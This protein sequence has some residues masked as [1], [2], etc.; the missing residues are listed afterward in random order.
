MQK[1]IKRDRMIYNMRLKNKIAR[2]VYSEPQ[3]NKFV[4]AIMTIYQSF[5]GQ[6]TSKTTKKGF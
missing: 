3:M 4:V 6:K 2:Q 1:K 5:D